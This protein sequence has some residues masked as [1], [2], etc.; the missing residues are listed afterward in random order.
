MQKKFT[1]SYFYEI[2]NFLI[3]SKIIKHSEN[4]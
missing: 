4:V 1:I 2:T 3:L